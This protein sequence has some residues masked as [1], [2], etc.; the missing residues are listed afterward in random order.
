MTYAPTEFQRTIY[1]LLSQDTALAALLGTTVGGVQKVFDF[2][3]QDEPFQYIIM[4]FDPWT[5]RS[6]ET[7][8]GWQCQFALEV[9]YREPKRGKLG[10]QQIQARLD[11]LLHN[12]RP[13]IDGWNIIAL[14]LVEASIEPQQD[15]VTQR[16]LQRF[17]LLIGEN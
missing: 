8:R 9:W 4:D 15:T 16:G 17:N 14:N 10:V 3:P 1:E 11:E 6:N 5:N 2:V 12:T 13:C 7:W